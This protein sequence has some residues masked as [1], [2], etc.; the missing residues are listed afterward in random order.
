MPYHLIGEHEFETIVIGSDQIWRGEWENAEEIFLGFTTNWKLN[1]F[2]YAASFG[3]P[4]WQYNESD[5]KRASFL[6]KNIFNGVS[7]REL[8]A[9]DLCKKHFGI[10]PVLTLDPV[11]LVDKSFY[12][13]L[14]QDVKQKSGFFVYLVGPKEEKRNIITN[15]KNKTNCNEITITNGV[16]EEWLAAFRDA[17]FIITDSFHGIAFSLLFNKP[18][19]SF[20]NEKGGNSRFATMIKLFNIGNRFVK[21]EITNDQLKLLKESVVLPKSFYKLR[22]ESLRFLKRNLKKSPNTSAIRIAKKQRLKSQI[23]KMLKKVFPAGTKRGKFAR[24]FW[25]KIKRFRNNFKKE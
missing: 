20:Y 11:F 8:D 3:V 21:N 10:T 5:T 17:D 13:N 6:L 18:F 23:K 2:V 25:I 12:I 19:L 9:I 14:C 7:V 4:E 15:F 16:A 22:K 24:F 1:R